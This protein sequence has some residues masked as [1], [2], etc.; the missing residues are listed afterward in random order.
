MRWGGWGRGGGGEDSGGTQND[1]LTPF[2]VFAV[3]NFVR[4]KTENLQIFCEETALYSTPRFKAKLL[5][6]GELGG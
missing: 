2:S 1:N 3:S 5:S 4:V 6:P